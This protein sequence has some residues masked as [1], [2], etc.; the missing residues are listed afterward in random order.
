MKTKI[1]CVACFLVASIFLQTASAQANQKLSN[2]SPT[3]VNQS[4]LPGTNNSINLGSTSLRWK[5]LHLENYLYLKGSLTMHRPG[6]T[7][8]FA[9]GN[10][11]NLSITG[12]TNTGIGQNALNHLTSGGANTANGAN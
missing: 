12:N 5:T 1:S 9:G 10:A 8:F 6:T 7:N 11:G 2:L 3:A 4:L